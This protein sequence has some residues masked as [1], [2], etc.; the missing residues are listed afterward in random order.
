MYTSGSTGVPKGVAITNENV[1]VL[2]LDRLWQAGGPPRWLMHAPHSF[3]ASAA[4]IWPALLTGGEVVM[5]PPGYLD[6]DQV[7]RVI[8]DRKITAAQFTPALFALMADQALPEL[9]KLRLV[10]TGGD[11]VS[12]G[13]FQRVADACPDTTVVNG[14]GPTET[15][16]AATAYPMPAGHRLGGG[17]PIGRPLD[18]TAAYVLDRYLRLVA[19]GTPGELYIG[20]LHV[21]RGYVAAP[22]LTAERFVADPFGPPGRRMYRTGD[23]ARWNADGTLDF[24]G[25]ADLQVKVRGYRVEPGEIEAVLES[26]PGVSRAVVI[27]RADGPGAARLVAYLV[28]QAAPVEEVRALA[29]RSL[30]AYMLPSAYVT[31]DQLPLTPHQKPDRNALPVPSLAEDDT[32]PRTAQER[33]LQAIFAEVLGVP[34]VGIHDNFFALGGHSLLATRLVNRVRAEFGRDIKI[35]IIFE[36]QTVATLSTR[37]DA[38]APVSRRPVLRRAQRQEDS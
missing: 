37:L 24:A 3:D 38:S 19:P 12:P 5:L 26:H 21:G 10:G 34:R 1:A 31:L 8:A 11:R 29:A 15:T 13:Y 30:P 20:G 18:N 7:A 32:A 4:E 2:A 28:P 6:A 23:V 17:V 33:E 27:A 14:Y 16:V 22:G 35:D 9:A 36:T 25:R